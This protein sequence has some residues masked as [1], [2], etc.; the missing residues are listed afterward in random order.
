MTSEGSGTVF[1]PPA[2]SANPIMCS[3]PEPPG[4]TKPSLRWTAARW[5]PLLLTY[6]EALQPKPSCLLPRLPVSTTWRVGLGLLFQQAKFS[7]PI[8]LVPSAQS[9][10]LQPA[11]CGHLAY[12]SQALL[13]G[14]VLC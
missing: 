4:P 7:H 8:L 11:P 12:T 10:H 2:V 5:V 13:L 9:S 14:L 1:L 6:C 3:E